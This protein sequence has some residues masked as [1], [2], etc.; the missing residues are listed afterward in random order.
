MA[1]TSRRQFL[2]ASALAAVAPALP[3]CRA[4]VRSAAANGR[5][6]RPYAGIDWKT[7][8]QVRGTS[9]VHCTTAAQLKVL[10]DRGIRF[11]TLSNYY[12]SAPWC[13][14]A[15]MTENYYRVHHDH[16]VTVRGRRME[17]PFN[18]NEIVGAWIDEL[19][20]K[21]RREHPFKEGAAIFPP[22]PSDVLEAPNAEHHSFFDDDGHDIYALHLNSLGSTF[23]SGTFDRRTKKRF[24]T[25][26]RGGYMTGSGEN[27]K[28]AVDRMLGGLVVPDGGGVTINHPVWT[29]LDRS[30]ALRMLDHDPRILGIE[31][32][33]GTFL[34]GEKYW[35]W[36][37]ATGRQCFGFF[38]PDHDISAPSG[39]FGV[40][41]LV[42][43]DRSVAGCLR[44]YRR[45]DF[46]GA[47]RGLGELNF[48]HISYDGRDLRVETDR[49]ARLEAVTARGIVRTVA[50]GTRLSWSVV[51]ERPKNWSREYREKS[52]ATTDVFVRVK[53]TS[54]DG[55]GEILFTQPF[56]LQG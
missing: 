31:V 20:E 42:T 44:A 43:H 19:P 2:A 37:L 7:A 27:W 12:P 3:G 22:L 15:K 45:G 53:A 47:K 10:L 11:L 25:F 35:D 14:L 18:W 48:T 26:A 1:M 28:T 36:I 39:D 16:A 41:V 6:R 33:E 50:S 34:E 9:H 52:S 51:P 21:V 54:L 13:P 56:L 5:N 29:G 17:G 55:S 32:I 8:H 4:P 40:N 38:V 23:A 49:P 46:Y 24:Q 30:F